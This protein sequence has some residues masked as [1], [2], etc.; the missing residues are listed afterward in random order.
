MQHRLEF[1]CKHIV[2]THMSSDML[3][4][5]PNLEVQAAYDG[6]EIIL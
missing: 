2:L 6:F 4:H 5:L 1:D 3:S